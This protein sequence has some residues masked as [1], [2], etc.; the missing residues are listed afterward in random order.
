MEKTSDI[1]K[2]NYEDKL[3]LTVVFKL[4]VNNWKLYAKIVPIVT[5]VGALFVFSQPRYY[6]CKIKLAPEASGDA[7]GLSSMLMQF[8][9]GDAAQTEDAISPNLYPDLMESQE[10]VV[11]LFPVKIQTN[12]AKISTTYYDY[13]DTKQKSSWME[14]VIEG[15]FAIFQ[16][17][18][19]KSEIIN[20]K[21]LT[22]HQNDIAKLV[23]NNIQYDYDKKNAIISI[24]VTDQ[25]PL[26]CATIADTISSRLQVSI[27]D[28]RT[29]K[30]RHD[31]AYSEKIW[32][33]A[34]E[35]YD[36]A[37]A[38]YTASIDSNWDIVDESYKLTQ[39]KLQ[40]VMDMKF[41]AYSAINTK[42]QSARIKVQENTPVFTVLQ[43][44]KVPVKPAGPKRMIFT[45][46]SFF[47]AFVVTSVYLLAKKS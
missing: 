28:Y 11:G 26:V 29:K 10:F 23:S 25:D 5:I 35:E 13:L 47:L 20:P 42:L 22:K 34:K 40:N 9:L 19:P 32:K 15:I 18:E 17:D 38:E 24:E 3:D 21:K 16:K 41:Q 8:G 1:N 45:L 46:A 31:L 39:K 12:D 4:L 30:A 43:G 2:I 6:E 44:S 36:K 33:E 14:K 37:A 7:G 27:T